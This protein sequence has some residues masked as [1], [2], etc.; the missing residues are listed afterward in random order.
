MKNLFRSFLL[1]IFGVTLAFVLGELSVRVVAPQRLDNNLQLFKP[2][3][4][5]IFTMEE[6]YRGV[7]SCYEFEV[8]IV[9]NS[10]GFRDKEIEPKSSQTF[11]IVG[12]GD[13]FTFANG[14]TLEETYLKQ[15]EQRMPEFNGKTIEVINCGV[16]AYT[17]LQEYRLLRTIEA[18]MQPDI[19]LV[20]FFVG[21]DLT[22]S[23]DMID[24]TGKPN[25][26]IDKDGTLRTV[27]GNDDERTIVRGWT[28][29]LRDFF[30]MRSH[31]YIFLR[32]RSSEMLSKL[33]LRPLNMPPDF[34]EKE[35]SDLMNQRWN[36]TQSILRDLI[37]LT[38]QHNQRLIFVLLP[39]IYQAYRTSWDQYIAALHL[40]PSRYDLDKPQK[41][42]A[43]FLTIHNVE[44]VDVLPLMRA[45]AQ[46]ERLYYPVDSHLS[47]EGHALVADA[48]YKYLQKK[49]P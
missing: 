10:S 40:E 8:P 45:K 47:P 20:G 26:R 46:E 11:R 37:A 48:L 5:L 14:V 38:K 16:P 35:Y 6:N 15:L 12:L 22:D 27:R 2:H 44:F 18:Q 4:Y 30:K 1:G 41:L 49:E 3:D 7:Y 19:V 39:T 42:L 9:T 36:F 28:S 13:S 32:N 17:L 33:G 21:N 29:R 25:V 24:S 43:D 31:L 23:G 34:C